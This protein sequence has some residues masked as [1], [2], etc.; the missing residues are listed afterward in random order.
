MTPARINFPKATLPPNTAEQIQRT[1]GKAVLPPST[2][3]QIQRTLGKAVLPPCTAEQIHRAL[4]K[5]VLPSRTTEQIHRTLG[6]SAVL[7]PSTAEQVR[8]ML[9]PSTAQQIRRAL[10]P[11]TA[12]RLRRALPP[13][14]A[15]QI[16]RILET[17][18]PNYADVVQR[19]LRNLSLT[20]AQWLR[21]D[22]AILGKAISDAAQIIDALEPSDEPRNVRWLM[23]L[24]VPAVLQLFSLYVALL[25]A[26]SLVA[27]DFGAEVPDP[28]QRAVGLVAAAVAALAGTL[29]A[30]DGESD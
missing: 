1:L 22:T 9:S 13:G 7:P 24:P 28:I 15:E 14:V 2:A 19:S 29:D 5:A 25:V 10:P 3:E 23:S 12:E 26:V 4:G 17:L 11:S 6:G 30:R 16:Q 8:R 21:M 27:E 20:H 18:R